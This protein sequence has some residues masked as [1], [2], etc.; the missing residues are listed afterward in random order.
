MGGSA[1]EQGDLCGEPSSLVRRLNTVMR[2]SLRLLLLL[3]LF[4]VAASACSAVEGGVEDADSSSSR[5]EGAGEGSLSPEDEAA[6]TADAV[7]HACV[8]C[9]SG[10]VYVREHLLTT[11]TL[12]GEEQPMPEAVKQELS[13]LF[14]EVVFVDRAEE[15]EVLG[16]DLLPDDGTVIYV[17]SV[18]ELKQDVVGVEVGTI[19]PGDGFK[20]QTVQFQWDGAAWIIA[21]SEDTGV[22]VT[23]AVS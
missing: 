5:V 12:V 3:S 2:V 20:A 10:T 9:Q 19:T 15:L 23:T 18:H 6:L 16:E 8:A 22:T 14:D 1:T 4:G 17:G 21:T 13:E 11:E 7:V